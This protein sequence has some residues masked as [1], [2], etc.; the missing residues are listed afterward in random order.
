MRRGEE[1]RA[2]FRQMRLDVMMDFGGGAQL[3]G[4]F[5]DRL[6]VFQPDR[7]N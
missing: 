6:G 2:E 5:R 4:F 3:E 7:A 1:L